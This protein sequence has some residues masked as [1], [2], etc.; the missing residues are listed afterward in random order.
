MNHSTCLS[1]LLMISLS[2]V[3]SANISTVQVTA[4]YHRSADF[5]QKQTIKLTINNPTSHPAHVLVPIPYAPTKKILTTHRHHYSVIPGLIIGSTASFGLISF[6]WGA[7][8]PSILV[9]IAVAGFATA[10]FDLRQPEAVIDC[11]HSLHVPAYHTITQHLCIKKALFKLPVTM[12]ICGKKYYL[13]VPIV[14]DTMKV[15]A[16]APAT[17]TNMLV[18]S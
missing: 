17:T 6:A 8:I 13:S 12:N 3:A 18:K 11:Q 4:S 2:G 7:I 14:P 5:L 1:S 10:F 9:G 15:L 16:A